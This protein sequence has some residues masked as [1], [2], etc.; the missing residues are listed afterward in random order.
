MADASPSPSPP[1]PFRDDI[2]SL[3]ASQDL[4]TVPD[5]FDPPERFVIN[6]IRAATRRRDLSAMCAFVYSEAPRPDTI[7]LG[8]TRIS[9]MQDGHGELSGYIVATNQDANNGMS[10]LCSQASPNGIME[11]LEEIS[12]HDRCT[13]IWDPERNVAT[14]YPFGVTSPDDHVRKPINVV[15]TD[16][17]QDEVNSA[18]Q[19]VY[20][21]NLKNPSARTAR[22]WVKLTLI[23][24]AEDELERHIKGQM[25]TF[26]VGRQRP[27][28]ILS[29]TNTDVGRCDLL[30]LQRRST[31]APT[32]M[33]VLE[34]KVLRGPET[35]NTADTRE[36]LSQGYHYHKDLGLPFAIL[37]LFDVANP[38]SDDLTTV[39]S[40]QPSKYVQA[41]LVVRLPIY[42]SPRAWRDST[43]AT[44]P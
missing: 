40:E 31:G 20:A 44:N 14:I 2:L 32:V 13:V 27:I 6:S 38:P 23:E 24:R 19:I 30:F 42:N 12:L 37:A 4:D 22:L 16:L 36:G 18:L 39:L 28:K 33:G 26:F 9:H 15:D 1:G 34:L 35:K 5:E 21:K 7:E 8:F 11:E 43:D 29:Q 41:V 10:R 25:T 3:V 17:T